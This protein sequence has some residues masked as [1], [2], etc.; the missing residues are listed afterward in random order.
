[1]RRLAFFLMVCL[2]FTLWSN[3]SE[4]TIGSFKIEWFGVHSRTDEQIR[5]LADYIRSLDIDILACQQISPTCD[6]S[7]N[8]TPDWNDLLRELGSNFAGWHGSTCRPQRL[9]FIWRTDRV[10][11][12][13][14]GELK[15]F[16]RQEIR[17]TEERT[18]PRIPITA[19]VRSLDG[20]VDF[21]IVTVH[22]Y[23]KEGIIRYAEA[24][25][26][27]DWIGKYL[28]GNYDKDVVLIGD[29]NTKS[30]G[31]DDRHDSTTI[32]NI[33]AGGLFTC[34]SKDHQE[35]TTLD[36]RERYDHAFL[37]AEFLVEYVE[38]SWDVRREL[39]DQ[40]PDTYESYISDHCPVTLRITDEDTDSLPTGDW[41]V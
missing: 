22:L 31:R 38:G 14:L 20:G 7:K 9:A 12:T 16:K 32:N 28:G 8:G 39:A 23:S 6:K 19:Y 13:D 18:F 21:R 5:L 30:M 36:A 2:L 3:A 11:V 25:C 35:Y 34:I 40:D 1:M 24:T 33:E 15:A 26:L 10:E 27:N 29:C 4:I 37:T 17:G 41:G